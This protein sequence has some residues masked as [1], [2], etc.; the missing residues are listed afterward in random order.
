MN[1]VIIHWYGRRGISICE[2]WNN[3]QNFY[4]WVM[5]N[6]YSSNLTLDRIDTNDNYKPKNCRWVTWNQQATNTRKNTDFAGVSFHKQTK[7]YI[8][9]LRK[10]G[11]DILRKHYKTKQEAITARLEAEA[12][13]SIEIERK[14][15]LQ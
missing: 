6:G 3:F 5:D 10:D 1:N 13:Y 4:Q 12:K 9:Y 7:G 14:E 8:A 15:A 2:E 11:K